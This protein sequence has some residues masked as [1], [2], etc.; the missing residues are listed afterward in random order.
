MGDAPVTRTVS[1][2]LPYFSLKS[3]PGTAWCY[4]HSRQWARKTPKTPRSTLIWFN[5]SLICWVCHGKMLQHSSDRTA[6]LT[7]HMRTVY[8]GCLLSI[9]VTVS[10]C[11]SKT[12]LGI[13]SAESQPN[14]F[15]LLFVKKINI[16]ALS[17]KISSLTFFQHGKIY[18]GL[19]YTGTHV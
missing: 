9:L 17:T 2:Q 11:S 5:T 14:K 4:W 15:Y 7:E 3:R 16:F 19:F 8:D 6:I 12:S 1:A 18:C 10:T 13:P